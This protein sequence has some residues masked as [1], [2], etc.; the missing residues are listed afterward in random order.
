M[1]RRELKNKINKI[2]LNLYFFLYSYSS[3]GPDPDPKPKL[4]FTTPLNMYMPT[5]YSLSLVHLHYAL[6]SLS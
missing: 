3:S 5:A 1:K 4:F 2:S 6:I